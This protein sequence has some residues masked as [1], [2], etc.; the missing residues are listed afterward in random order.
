MAVTGENTE[1]KHIM[2]IVEFVR[3]GLGNEE[4]VQRIVLDKNVLRSL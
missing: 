2:R 1:T 4:Q 3:R